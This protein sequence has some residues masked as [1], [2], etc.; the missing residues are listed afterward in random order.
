MKNSQD[1]AKALQDLARKNPFPTYVDNDLLKAAAK[2]MTAMQDRIDALMT[3][4]SD[5]DEHIARLEEELAIMQE[6]EFTDQD[7]SFIE[8]EA[9]PEEGSDDFWDDMW[10]MDP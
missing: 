8:D 9:A 5:K 10:P 6:D 1:I 4:I 7:A 2:R 3:E